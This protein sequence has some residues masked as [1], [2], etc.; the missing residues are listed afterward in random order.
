[1]PDLLEPPPRLDLPM[2]AYGPD[3][4]DQPAYELLQRYVARTEAATLAVGG[5][6]VRDGLPLLDPDGAAG[7]AG[8][9]LTFE[10][11]RE[12]DAYTTV[13]SV[14]PRQH[15]RWDMTEMRVDGRPG[16]VNLL[17]GRHPD[18]GSSDEWFSSWSAGD[19]PLLRYGLVNV[20]RAALLHATAPF[21]TVT[22]DEA[23]MWDRFYG[24]Q[25][26]YL[27]LWSAVERF[28]ALAYGPAQPA[29]D[30]TW[31]LG[32]DAKFR[33]CVV[34]AGVSPS[35]KTAD[36]RDPTRARRIREDGAGAMFS[37]DAARHLVAHPG[38]TAFT[39]GVLLR[40]SLID[41][42]DAFRLTLLDRLPALT[43]TWRLADPGGADQRWLL[44][45][46]VAPEALG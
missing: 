27:L 7:V 8:V 25:A 1:M 26:A 14:A 31:R 21:P 38:R 44:R 11:G 6:R 29:L 12:K 42:H 24:L 9:L 3:K 23:A 16:R 41:L 22:G 28:T 13:C 32:D 46:S 37:W 43:A 36:S 40:R 20:R 10:P 2:F 4:P 39:D 35:A 18:R 30:R 19:D 34:A 33:A 45:P 5:L 17:R 15:Y